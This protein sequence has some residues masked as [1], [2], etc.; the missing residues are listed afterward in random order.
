MKSLIKNK[1]IYQGA[2]HAALAAF[3]LVLLLNGCKKSDEASGGPMRIDVVYLQDVNSDVPDRAVEFAR[4]GQTIRIEGEG[5]SGV[6]RIFINGYQTS[7]NS[8]LFTDHNIWLSIAAETPTF[9]ANPDERNTIVLEKGGQLYQYAFEIRSSAPTVT[10]ISH[11]MPQAG[12]EITIY[13]TGLQ[14][15]ESITFP[16]GITVTSG[17]VSDDEEGTYCT[18]TVPDNVS[19]EGGALLLVGANG[20]VYSPA[21]FNFKRGL[22][23]NF[24][25]VNTAS[26]SNGEISE[27]L[28]AL[29]PA[30]G[31]GPKSQGLYRSL[32]KD[33]RTMAA[34]DAAVDITRYWINNGV[35]GSMI[36]NTVIPGTTSTDQVA[37]QLDIY[38][39]G[40]WNS[41][42]IR[43]VVADGFGTTRYC[44]LYAP[45]ESGGSRV[46]FENPGHWFTVTLPF[47]DSEDF[48][49]M[50]FQGVLSLL[51]TVT[52]AQAGPW[53]ENGPI[54]GVPAENTN[55]NVYFDNIRIV[56]LSTPAFSD[57]E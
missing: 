34:S 11:T 8:A 20:G 41:G 21:Y 1:S 48:A 44:M 56:P 5:F 53:L 24:D 19:D 3:L 4:I 57:F 33:S 22:L 37:V 30:D 52:Y 10:S 16:G 31:N 49:G 35:W 23:H 45:W 54:N 9:D 2:A 51:S 42:N 39:Q 27:D 17:I 32:N 36:D 14:G 28:D 43:F 6:E 29:L 13:G 18:V 55:V 25:N 26:W 12:E 40:E 50:D 47:S 38:V 7:F 46:P 15:I